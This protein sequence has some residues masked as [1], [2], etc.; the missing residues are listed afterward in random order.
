MVGSHSCADRQRDKNPRTR[1]SVLPTSLL[2]IPTRS[3]NTM[4]AIT[5]APAYTQPATCNAAP[6][7]TLGLCADAIESVTTVVARIV[8]K[9]P[10]VPRNRETRRHPVTRFWKSIARFFKKLCKRGKD[11]VEDD[12]TVY[13]SAHGSA[14]S[15][16][17]D[18][19]PHPVVPGHVSRSLPHLSIPD[20]FGVTLTA[21]RLSCLAKHDK[22]G[23]IVAWLNES[24]EDSSSS[25]HG[26]GGNPAAEEAKQRDE[27]YDPSIPSPPT[28]LA[29]EEHDHIQAPVMLSSLTRQGDGFCLVN[30]AELSHD[31]R[32]SLKKIRRAL[33]IRQR[34]QV[35]KSPHSHVPGRRGGIFSRIL[36]RGAAQH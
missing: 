29:D 13:L 20:T 34:A 30:D 19:E 4:S 31:R 23:R 17:D 7:S 22:I 33:C 26:V 28:S 2:L 36:R 12:P 6:S 11:V 21:L 9:M 5:T 15:H 27:P 24:V 16:D 32:F 18:T 10:N 25:D 3:A 14:G 35:R 8:H 1:S